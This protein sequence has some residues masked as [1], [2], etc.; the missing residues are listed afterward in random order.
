MNEL[1]EKVARLQWL[2]HKNQI[3]QAHPRSNLADVTRGQGRIL[4]ALKMQDGISTKELSYILGLAVSS[5]NEF[6]AKLE[7]R[8]YITRVPFENDKRVILVKLTKKGRAEQQIPFDQDGNFDAIFDCL[9]EDEQKNLNTYLDKLIDALGAKLGFDEEEFE[10]VKAAHD[11]RSKM[12]AHMA[13]HGF[14]P[15][16]TRRGGMGA[17]GRRPRGFHHNHDRFHDHS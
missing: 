5:L 6:L 15:R 4:A 13:A 7:K 12:F 9:T 10:W 11:K 14:D 3:H 16:D 2:L 8:G 17:W 1:Y